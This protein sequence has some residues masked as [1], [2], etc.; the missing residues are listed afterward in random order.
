[1][2]TAL[3]IGS[4]GNLGK[5]LCKHLA[6]TGYRVLQADIKPGY[7]DNFYT[8]DINHPIDLL[9]AFD[10]KPDV[11]FLLAG[12]VGRMACEQAASLSISTNLAGIN[13]VIQLCKRTKSHL[14]YFS[15]SEVYGPDCDPMDEA[16]SDPQPN[17]R[18]GL[19][20]LLG[21]KLVE[22]EVR[23]HGLKASTVRPCMIYSEDEDFGD[24]RSAMI[25][26]AWRL[27]R[28]QQIEVHRGTLRGWMHV[29]D[30][31]RATE[32]A[33]R[34]KEYMAINVGHPDVR[35]IEELAEMIRRRLGAPKN[36]I[37]ENELPQRM[38]S[39]KRPVLKRQTEDLGVEC[40]VS[41]EQGVDRLVARVQ[42]RLAVMS[43]A[44]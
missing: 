4:E 17:N 7:R 12:I 24:H 36:L 32:A 44:A 22:Y 9:P 38:T 27:A 1:M 3:V 6:E 30:L 13:N 14:V 8:A 43:R 16:V 18:Y 11:V 5:P 35:P 21:E 15:T 28:G 37:I 26:F 41:L 31:A 33:G 19:E 23:N 10:Q 25:R 2:R 29:T 34:V 40:L 39:I 42:E 20:K